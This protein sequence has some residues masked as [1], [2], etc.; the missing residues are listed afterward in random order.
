MGRL[1]SWKEIKADIHSKGLTIEEVA[2]QMH[3]S[4]AAMRNR[5][6]KGEIDTDDM[7]LEAKK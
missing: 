5:Y 6:S 4:A 1:Y 7:A 3:I 2:Y